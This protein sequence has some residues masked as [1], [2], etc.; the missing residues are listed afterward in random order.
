[1]TGRSFTPLGLYNCTSPILPNPPAEIRSLVG[2]SPPWGRIGVEMP[3]LNWA[4]AVFCLCSPRNGAGSTSPSLLRSGT[5]I[6]A[7]SAVCRWV[8]AHSVDL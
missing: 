3:P 6:L 5:G 2:I 1:M 7:S 8:G 4:A